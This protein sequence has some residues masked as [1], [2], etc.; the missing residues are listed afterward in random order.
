MAEYVSRVSK[1]VDKTEY[2]IIFKTNDVSEYRKIQEAIRRIIDRNR[3]E[4][5]AKEREK[6]G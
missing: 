6:N 5:E 3:A 4:H 1:K 2:E